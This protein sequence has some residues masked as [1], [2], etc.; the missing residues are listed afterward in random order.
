MTRTKFDLLATNVINVILF[1]IIFCFGFIRWQKLEEVVAESNNSQERFRNIHSAL[2]NTVE[3]TNLG[4]Q[5]Y[6]WADDDVS[7]YKEKLAEAGVILDKLG[8][9]YPTAKTD[10]M[11]SAVS[12]SSGMYSHWIFTSLDLFQAEYFVVVFLISYYVI[13]K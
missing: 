10:S 2:I 1:V 8:G 5:V 3:L 6:G 13:V 9:F 7:Q 4:E 12:L 11:K